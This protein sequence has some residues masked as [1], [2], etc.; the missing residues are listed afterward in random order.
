MK[1]SD[2][3]V[4]SRV[5]YFTLF[6]FS[7]AVIGL[8]L[9]VLQDLV[10]P[11][12]MGILAAYISLPVINYLWR[13]GIPKSLAILIL[14]GAFSI[15]IF[16]IGQKV[17]SVI[18]NEKENL[19][20]RIQLQYKL[21]QNFL[22]FLGK[23]DYASEGNIFDDLFGDELYQMFQGLSSYLAFNEIEVAE[24][25]S[26]IDSS[27]VSSRILF[28]YN[29][30][31]KHPILPILKNDDSKAYNN[32]LLPSISDGK[33]DS[34]IALFLSAISTWI[35]MPFIFIFV[36]ID[37]GEIKSFFLNIVPNRYFEM[38]F[39]TFANVDKAIGNYLRGTLMQSSLVGL[40]IFLGLLL[41]GFKIQAAILIG[42][43][44]GISNAI[45]F[46]GPVIGLG[47]GILYAMIVEG[48]DPVLP[49][50]PDNPIFGVLLVV[51]IAQFLDNA[52]FQPL[53]LGKAVNLH[54]LVVV[55]GVT[56]GSIIAGFW[57]VLLAIPTIVIFKVVISTV[58]R[59]AKA[60][61]IIY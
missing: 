38:A 6:I 58:Y 53:V 60:Y 4:R 49:F 19:E 10:L 11:I 24:F 50:L 54:P 48:I 37:E 3:I 22:S 32:E 39:T 42:I 21:D 17:V 55:I 45:P 43:I 5:F 9:V 47:T 44:A 34:K 26:Y 18:P 20:L 61:Y 36:L 40:T 33:S 1:N 31:L 25:Q 35:I 13:K 59:Q 56:G 8:L 12:L 7:V 41:I 14:L 51:L 16:V 27:Q 46:L 30:N 15:I 52:I 57:G 2:R 23:K 29:E 28:F